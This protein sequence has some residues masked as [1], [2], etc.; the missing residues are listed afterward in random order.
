MRKRAGAASVAVG[1][2]GDRKSPSPPATVN[3]E[4]NVANQGGIHRIAR[5]TTWPTRL[6]RDHGEKSS[7]GSANLIDGIVAQ[8]CVRHYYAETQEHQLTA[9]I[10]GTIEWEMGGLQIDG[11]T[12][13]IAV[14]DLSDR[15]RGS[16]ER[17]TG[18]D[19]YISVVLDG[20]EQPISKGMLVQAKWDDTFSSTDADMGEQLKNMLDRTQASHVWVYYPSGAISIP[21]ID[22]M[23]GETERNATTAGQLIAGGLGCTEGDPSIGRDTSKEIVDSLNEMLR[24]LAADKAVG[25]TVR[26]RS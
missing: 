20:D 1:K 21:A 3:L 8:V 24:E 12:V 25:V 18:A 15:G 2:E 10:A 26:S 23:N 9:K 5:G 7:K 16:K 19:L 17:K 22:V 6:T 4:K 14:Q 11:Y 13:G